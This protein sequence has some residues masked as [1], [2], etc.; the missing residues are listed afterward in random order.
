MTLP[1]LASRKVRVVLMESRVAGLEA[2]RAGFW[3]ALLDL[4]PEASPFLKLLSATDWS[5]LLCGE[6]DLTPAAVKQVLAFKG[7]PPSSRVPT[8]LPQTIDQFSPDNL[9]RFL[10]FCT[11][12][13]S[14][15]PAAK[16]SGFEI[17][18]QYC[19]DA[20]G[21]LPVAHTCFFKLDLPDYSDQGL[22]VEKLM[23][24]IQEC[25]TFDRV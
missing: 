22:F 20:N 16:Q 8:W 14:L 17:G 21:S 19:R 3:Q 12:S 7:Y 11:G 1:R 23:K 4:S 9:R 6:E 25:G 24:S 5:L 15:P 2:V 18:V 10:I 13:P